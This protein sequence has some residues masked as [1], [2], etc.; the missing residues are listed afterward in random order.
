VL[1]ATYAFGHDGLTTWGNILERH[2]RGA[3][4]LVIGGAAA[5]VLLTG[6]FAMGMTRARLAAQRQMHTQAW[7]LRQLLP[8]ARAGASE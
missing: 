6:R 1:P 4:V 3:L 2:P 5:M 8:R 7:Q